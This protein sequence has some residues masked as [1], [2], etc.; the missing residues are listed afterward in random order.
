MKP[1]RGTPNPVKSTKLALKPMALSGPQWSRCPTWLLP[2]IEVPPNHLKLYHSIIRTWFGV[3]LH[4]RNQ[5]TRVWRFLSL[6]GFWWSL[7]LPISAAHF[8]GGP[9]SL[10][11][12]VSGIPAKWQT[13]VWDNLV[14][15]QWNCPGLLTGLVFIY[16]FAIPK[17]HRSLPEED[18]QCSA[19]ALQGKD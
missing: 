10:R 12:P 15:Q 13:W 1:V 5:L 11:M 6:K 8:T 17:F 9:A 14:N 4:F 7:Y 19:N 16:S 2:K 18:W 3:A